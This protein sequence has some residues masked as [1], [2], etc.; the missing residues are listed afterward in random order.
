MSKTVIYT[1]LSAQERWQIKALLTSGKSIRAIGF[2][3]GRSPSTIHRELARG[4]TQ[5]G[6]YSPKHAVTKACRSRSLSGI[7]RSKLDGALWKL[8]RN[9]LLQR[10]S[11]EQ[12]AGRFTLCGAATISHSTIY[13][14][15][16]RRNDARILGCLRHQGKRY[17]KHGRAGRSLIPNRVD[18]SQRPDI[19]RQKQRIGDWEGDT[20]VSGKNGSGALVTLVDRA[21][22]Y[23]CIQRVERKTAEQ[24]NQ[25][26]MALLKP[27]KYKTHTI[28]YDNGAEFARHQ[29]INTILQSQSYFA[30]PYHSWERG[31]NEHTNGLIRQF[32]PKKTNFK[33]ITDMEVNAVQKLLNN[34]PRKVLNYL[35]PAEA[36]FRTIPFHLIR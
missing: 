34:R 22:K 17:K 28:T 13:R 33:T 36:F 7:K 6:G 16:Y 21:S 4:R 14:G 2:Q 19:V 27:Y 26:I 25:A 23:T 35:T 15:I 12:I 29:H 30:T 18:I 8:V 5:K 9:C 31:L 10:W 20:V 3:L 11:P 32:F 1:H 24:V